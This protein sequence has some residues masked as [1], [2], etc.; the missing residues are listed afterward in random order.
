MDK[1]ESVP[2]AQVQFKCKGNQVNVH[3]VIILIAM[4]LVCKKL[5]KSGHCANQRQTILV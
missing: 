3:K 5:F 2:C 4:H 1:S